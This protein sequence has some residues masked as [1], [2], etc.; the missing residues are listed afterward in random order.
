MLDNL[1]PYER[2]PPYWLRLLLLSSSSSSSS[3]SS[4]VLHLFLL[5]FIFLFLF[6][7]LSIFS[8]FVLFSLFCVNI[9]LLSGTL[10]Y[11]GKGPEIVYCFFSSL[12]RKINTRTLQF[13]FLLSLSVSFS[14]SRFFFPPKFDIS[15][16]TATA[17][18]VKL[19]S[20]KYRRRRFGSASGRQKNP[21]KI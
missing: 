5:V 19:W 1:W 20:G 11:G 13:L 6:F 12:R 15:K 8:S 10:C 16:A 2:R 7:F 17:N 9:H 21:A 18:Q 4:W 14:Y 3:Y